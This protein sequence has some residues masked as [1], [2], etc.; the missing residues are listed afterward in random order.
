[1][2]FVLL[3][4]HNPVAIRE[5]IESR[6]YD[7]R[8][9]LRD[10]IRKPHV[11]DD[12]MIVSIDEKSIRGIG[13]WPWKREVMAELINRISEARPK[14]IGVDIMFTEPDNATS[15][16]KLAEAISRA[17][18][19]VLAMPF[20]V[21]EGKQYKGQV[22]ETPDYLWEQAFMEVRSS[23]GIDW[24][25]WVITADSVT[26]P[27]ETIARTSTLGHVYTKNDLDAV[28][29]WEILYLKFGDDYYP[30]FSLQVARLA[31]GLAPKDI[32][33]Y[34][35]SGLQFGPQFISTDLSGKV[36]IN[37]AGREHTYPYLSA[38]DI[39]KD[40]QT[41]KRL[42][43]KIVLVGTT[44][45]ATYDRKITPLSADTPGIE[46]NA[47]LVGNIINNNFLRAS[48]GIVE[49]VVIIVTGIFLGLLLPKLG[50][51]PSLLVTAG[52]ILL[53]LI[54]SFSL[55]I[56][57]N[58]WVNLLYPTL[59]MICIAVVQTGLRFFY[60]ERQAKEIRRIFSSYVSPKIVRE[61]IDHPEKARLGGERKITTILFSDVIGFTCL[62]ERREP[63]DVVALLNEYFEEMTD[64]IFKWEGTLDKFVGDEIM[65]LWG[66]P[67]EQPDHA[68]RAVQC[69]L[70]MSKKLDEM[71]L[72]WARRGVEGLDCGIGI[73]TGVVVI[74]NIGALGKK[75]DYTAIGDHVNLAAR[76]EKL[77]REYKTRILITENTYLAIK[78][79]ATTHNLGQDGE[80]TVVFSE[81]GTV[82][83]KG[84]EHEVR[85]YGCRREQEHTS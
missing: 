71:R 27:V 45:L 63:E 31:L 60:E 15:D 16:L 64:I 77:T 42:R 4:W 13:R 9:R 35:G 40:S 52:F 58:L 83:V 72:V 14:V 70:D 19:V 81:L 23:K 67:A 61:L 2:I 28:V 79:S 12:I 33:V 76:V 21:P 59:N 43:D 84:K 38:F 82:R 65:V 57:G 80:E 47:T 51:L 68:E 50:A 29:R 85:I 24:L 32:V 25:K 5:Y 7:F 54:T 11:S 20:F 46:I 73:N 37:Y 75:M 22:A 53:Y 62:S 55:L 17:G 48:P 1:M 56:Y 8:L 30:P 34:G 74:G 36:L 44:A 49:M 41:A 66:A 18:N 69:A 39:L 26:L 3:Q 10:S 6:T 78:D